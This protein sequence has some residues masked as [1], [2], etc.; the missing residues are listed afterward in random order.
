MNRLAAMRG[1]PGD[2]T[3]FGLFLVR[4]EFCD[5]CVVGI[6]FLRVHSCVERRKTAC[7]LNDV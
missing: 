4:G 7:E 3:C 6:N 1:P 2:A 5:N